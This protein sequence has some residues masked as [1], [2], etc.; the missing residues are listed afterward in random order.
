LLSAADLQEIAQHL[1]EDL[2]RCQRLIDH[3]RAFG[4]PV[5]AAPILV[6]LNQPIEMSL[7]L[8]GARLRRR[9]VT[10]HLALAD[11]L[12]LILA[13]PYRLEQ[14]FLN[15]IGNAEYALE[16]QW[17]AAS[18]AAYQKTLTITTGVVGE[19]VAATVRD[20]G[21]GIPP[22]AQ[23]RLFEAFFTTKPAGEGTGLGLSI[24]RGI[25]IEF[26][27]QITFESAVGVGTTFTLRF[28]IAPA[29]ALSA[30]DDF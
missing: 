10:L 21:C 1:K 4:R 6:T 15:L 8:L 16:Q 28:P 9:N 13:D 24:S 3:L 7:M 30:P 17:Q 25:V 5:S 2:T 27:G 29:D 14:V 18:A 11:D 19:Q 26:G 22:E 23:A 12:P 20:N